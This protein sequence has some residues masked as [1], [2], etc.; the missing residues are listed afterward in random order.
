M[1]KSQKKSPHLNKKLQVT[2]KLGKGTEKTLAKAAKPEP[3]ITKKVPGA[4]VKPTGDSKQTKIMVLLRRP[5]GATIDE[6]TKATG[7]QRHSVQGMM[8]GVLKKKLG[9]AVTSDKEERGRVYRITGSVS[10]L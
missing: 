2:R 10:R 6:M 5:V 7:W 1:P 4:L 9:L 8:S 3:K